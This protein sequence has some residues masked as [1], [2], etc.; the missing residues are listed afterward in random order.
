MWSYLKFP[1]TKIF[2]K[3][4][5]FIYEI[6]IYQII[7]HFFEFWIVFSTIVLISEIFT[8]Y[9]LI[10]YNI[11]SFFLLNIST[12]YFKDTIFWYY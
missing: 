10:F 1:K 4:Y 7:Y 8:F 12:K 11:R 6:F 9:I 3:F 2:I 5:M